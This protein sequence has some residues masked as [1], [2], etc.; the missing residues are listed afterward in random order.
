[1][2]NMLYWQMR[3]LGNC[4][5]Q[6]EHFLYNNTRKEGTQPTYF[7][8]KIAQFSCPKWEQQDLAYQWRIAN[9]PW[10]RRMG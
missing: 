2:S 9:F 4:P 8:T 3:A 7:G 1:M 6:D 10:K 5:V